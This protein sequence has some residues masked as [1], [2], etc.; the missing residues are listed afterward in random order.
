MAQG[1]RFFHLIE[2]VFLL[3]FDLTLLQQILNVFSITTMWS[4]SGVIV[5]PHF[6]QRFAGG[7]YMYNQSLI[8]VRRVNA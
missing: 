8:A 5:I 2:L 6:V 1:D 4:L 3:F 7:R